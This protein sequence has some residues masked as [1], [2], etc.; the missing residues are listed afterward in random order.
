MNAVEASHGIG[1]RSTGKAE[2]LH[3]AAD[4][5]LAAGL[6]LLRKVSVAGLS[7]KELEAALQLWAAESLPLPLQHYYLHDWQISSEESGLAAIPRGFLSGER[8]KL[9]RAGKKVASLRVQELCEPGDRRAGLI[10]WSLSSGCLACFWRDGRLIDWQSFP[11]T[12]SAEFV[13]AQLA[14]A[15]RLQPE[16]ILLMPA[17]SESGQRING[18]ADEAILSQAKRRWPRA[19]CDSMGHWS[20]KQRD[21]WFGAG[22]AFEQ[23]VFEH[24]FAPATTADKWRLGIAVAAVAAAASLLLMSDLQQREAEAELLRQ[25]DAVASVKARRSEQVASRSGQTLQQVYELRAL[26]VERKGVLEALREVADTLPPTIKLEAFTIDRIGQIE[27]EG[28]AETEIDISTLIQRLGKS[29]SMRNPV[30]AFAQKGKATDQQ[31]RPVIQ[32]R[33]EISRDAP[34]LKSS[35]AGGA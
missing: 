30:L 20:E 24:K 15:G 10:F 25:H 7:K 12:L 1:D 18:V 13:V 23:F 17:V 3:K 6:C 35:E 11:D 9:Y 28:S 34:L 22:P 14:T 8:E 29:S 2:R 5:Q 33:I 27:L 32:F 19:Q 4:L 26:T 31:A 16:W 21:D